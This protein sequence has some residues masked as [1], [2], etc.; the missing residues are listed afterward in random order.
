MAD[1]AAAKPIEVTFKFPK[2]PTSVIAKMSVTVGD[3]TI[4]A[5][6]MEKT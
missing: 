1:E 6:V 5:K 4:D 3:K 2:E